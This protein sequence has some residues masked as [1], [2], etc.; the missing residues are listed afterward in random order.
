MST[1]CIIGSG[2]VGLAYAVAMADLGNDVIGVDIDRERIAALTA[3]KTPIY[4]PGLDE[5]L[6]RNLSAGRLSFTTDLAPAL[7]AADF[8]FLCVGT[9]SLSGGAAD[10]RQVRAAAIAIGRNLVPGRQVVIVNKSTM[11]IGSA[12]LVSQL[13]SEHANQDATF[14]VVTNPEFLREGSAIWDIFHPDRIV[15]GSTDSAAAQAVA[16]LYAPLNA[17]VLYTDRKSAEMVKYAANAFLATKISFI[18]EVAKICERLDADVTTVARG[19]GLDPRIGGQFLEAGV[20]FGGSCFPKDVAALARMAD[21]VGLHP[22]LLRAVLEINQ[23]MRRQY[24]A[25]AETLLPGLDER[26]IGVLGLSFKEDTDDLRESPAMDIIAM[27]QE[28]GALVR[29]YD[30]AAMER[31]SP[32]LPGVTMC[33]SSYE[34]ATGSDAVMVITPWREFRQIDPDRLASVMRGDLLLDG[35]NLYDPRVIAAAGLRYVG[36]GRRVDPTSAPT[37]VW[38]ELGDGS[39]TERVQ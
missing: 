34:A 18:N 6:T 7:A 1:I 27:L 13:I 25:K 22:Q 14:H 39:K 33:L 17:P 21:T 26:V 37:V 30:P 4:E 3:G 38:S 24:V 28:R 16:A 10:M 5:L 35:R 29:A 23:D 8:A 31:A 2:Y 12:D 19:V 20:G 36:I 15:L 11:P 32:L 9:P